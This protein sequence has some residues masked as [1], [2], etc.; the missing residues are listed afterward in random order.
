MKCYFWIPHLKIMSGTN[1]H[2]NGTSQ[3]Q[4]INVKATL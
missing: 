4:I 2:E 1:F 3:T